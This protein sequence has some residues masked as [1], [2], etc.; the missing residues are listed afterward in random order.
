MYPFRTLFVLANF[1]FLCVLSLANAEDVP[2]L[3]PDGRPFE[4]WERPQ[5]FTQTYHVDQSHPRA[6]D[7]NNGTERRPWKTIGRAAAVLRPGERVIVH[8]GVYREWVKPVNGGTSADSMIAYEAAPGERVVVTGSDSWSPEWKPSHE[9][10]LKDIPIWQAE[11]TGDLFEGANPFC[12]QNFTI[13]Q[14]SNTWKDFP[15]FELRRGQIFIDGAYLPQVGLFD[16]LAKSSG[17]FWVSENGMTVFLRMP[18]DVPPQGHVFEITTREQVFA[19]VIP[20]L[21][22]IRVSGFTLIRAANGVPIPPPQRGL[23]SATRG[24]HWI[25]ED[26]EIAYANTLGMDLGGQWWSYGSGE[27]QGFHIVRRNFLHHCGVSSMSAWHNMANQHLLVEDN[28]I[29]DNCWMPIGPHYESAGVKF[30]ST[31]DSLIRRNV[32]L[33]T[34]NGPALWLDGEVRNTRITQNLFVNAQDTVG[35]GL[36]CLEINHGPNLF[37]NNILIGSNAHGF[38]EHDVDRAIVV[39]NLIANGT[40]FAIH[41]RPGDPNRVNPPLENHHRVYGNIATGFTECVFIP[42]DTTRS[43]CNVFSGSDL[44]KAFARGDKE[45]PMSFDAWKGLGQDTHSLM[46]PMTV[47]FDESS[48]LLSLTGAAP[49][50]PSFDAFPE[51]L[52]EVA[53]AKSLLTHDYFG[54]PRPSSSFSVGPFVDVPLDGSP[55]PVDVRRQSVFPPKK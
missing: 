35:L 37:D 32:V 1:A 12:L 29:S 21:N 30:H 15:S 33:R 18:N 20:Y 11:L 52:P 45:P 42:N 31:E 13:Q 17:Q 55:I 14:E 22:Y 38:H 36:V 28:L 6:S 4:S 5:S 43:D 24:H 49:K 46:L 10:K 23:L 7:Q 34:A 27:A 39:Q 16:D 19:P 50:L 44:S 25:I 53:A 2:V 54:K 8:G 9:F 41:L 51:L 40:G 47:Q 48:L 3:L 26:C